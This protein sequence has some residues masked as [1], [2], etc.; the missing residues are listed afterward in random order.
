MIIKNAR[1]LTPEGYFEEGH[2]EIEQGRIGKLGAGS[3]PG[4]DVGGIDA[5]GYVILPGII[6]PHVHFREPG[7]MYKEGIVNASR[8]ALKG[9]VTT[10]IDMPNNRPPITTRKRALEKRQRFARKALVNWGIMLHATDR[11]FE[12][13]GDLVKSV[14]IYM[15]KSSALPAI[16]SESALTQ[17]F[18]QYPLVSIHAEDESYF[19]PD[20]KETLPHHEWRPRQAVIGALQKIE[21]ALKQ[22]ADRERPHVVICHMNTRDEVEWLKRMKAEGFD[23][24]G[25]TCPHYLFFTQDD[26][27]NMGTLLQVNPPIRTKADQQ[28]LL[29]G[30]SQGVIDFIGTD[31]AP[32]TLQEKQSANPPSGIAAIEWLMPQMLHLIDE[33][34]IKWT[35]LN[36]LI[37]AASAWCYHIEGRD[38]IR[39]GNWADL[40]LV[41]R[42]EGNQRN[43]GVVTRSGVNVYRRFDFRW[44]VEMT[45]VN[46]IVKFQ[47][48]R[49]VNDKKGM[50]V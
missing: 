17:V 12:D 46:G 45:L 38:G 39:E 50:A 37:A 25:E 6:D 30:L 11:R 4:T 47:K 10:V 34:V 24:W 27:L 36:R 49:F 5:R 26:Y 22:V 1:W 13:P 20:K 14:K 19:L 44:R 31:H 16:T 29:N 3:A 7:Q 28:A 43:D 48:G 33:G 15:A 18:K 9:G 21:K 23:V 41:K 40:V 42:F 32:H 8:A 2:M 35:Q